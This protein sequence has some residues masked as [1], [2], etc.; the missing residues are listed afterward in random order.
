LG[1]SEL[2]E[3]ADSFRI[4]ESTCT[5]TARAMS[6][7]RS[8][9]RVNIRMPDPENRVASGEIFLFNHFARFETF[10]PQHL[11]LERTGAYCRSIASREFFN[12]SR[13]SKYL[14]ALGAVPNNYPRLLPFLAA[15]ILRGRKVV[16]FPEGGMVKDRRVVDPSG[17]FKVY[18]K[19]SKQQ[20]RHHVGAA[21]LG[22]GLDAF[23]TGL[24]QLAAQ[25]EI[26]ELER[27]AKT[28][29]LDLPDL[30]AAAAR[31]TQIVPSNITFY[32]LRLDDNLV[33]R[34]AEFFYRNLRKNLSEELLI[35][36]NI[37]LKDTDM[38]IRLG[39]PVRPRRQWNLLERKFL[40]FLLRRTH[41]L[42]SLFQKR[43]ETQRFDHRL[44]G[45]RLASRVAPLRDDCAREMY[46]RT[47][48]NLAHVAAR[49]TLALV[50]AGTTQID[51]K[52]FHRMLYLAARGVRQIE[53]VHLHDSLS[54]PGV[55]AALAEDRDKGLA[56]FLSTA[57]GAGLIALRG[58]NYEF[59]PKLIE[60][61]AFDSIR[62]ENPVAVQSNEVAPLVPVV[63]A[64]DRAVSDFDVLTPADWARAAF[65]DAQAQFAWDKQ[66]FTHSRYRAINARE[67]ASEPADP[68]LLVPQEGKRKP[69]GVVLV[70]GFLA[71]PAELRQFG[72]RLHRAGYPVFGVRLNG[73]GT[74]PWDLRDRSWENWM[75]P[76]RQGVKI[77]GGL[78]D[79]VCLV[80]FSSGGALS[81]ILA[82][83]APDNLAGVVSVSTPLKF[84][85]KNL[86]FVPLIHG[87]N[88]ITQW[89]PS[90]EGVM[91]FRENQ[92]EH[93]HINYRNISI[94]GL[95]ELRRMVDALERRLPS[96]LCPVTL[97][98]GD[99]ETVVEPR[100]VD[101]IARRLGTTKKV[102]HVVPSA[103]HGILNEDI[104]GTQDLVHE[105]IDLLR[106]APAQ[107]P[108]KKR[109]RRD[110]AE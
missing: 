7:L 35:E 105:A 55:Y 47:T 4:N 97:V 42:D 39:E 12:D 75:E 2:L 86:F 73:H 45:W 1:E 81:L 66:L 64:I 79:R 30:L 29:E 76:V 94:R 54:D 19:S 58:D 6:A 21:V 32:P 62:M 14:L 109:P 74:S 107:T 69:L 38:D 23:K 108:E 44:L 18:S 40:A 52:R 24:L 102:V 15:E 110:A 25:E 49:V 101:L 106:D 82:A 92:S 34:T 27:W 70:H 11:I 99:S 104:A 31:P 53:N 72:E 80:G 16:V 85:N 8:R 46:A 89:V 28:I 78:A 33:K 95:F 61:H 13:L 91:P 65:E 63:E 10:I 67:T 48:V 90:L 83:E 93:P 57:S 68:Y 17:G 9:L 37:L 96:V 51:R 100:S 88:T 59:S 41:S 43:S 71:S 20:R 98:Q 77:M 87:A 60:K 26:D 22:L 36:G 84:R 3:S 56:A 50:Q 103:R 5:W